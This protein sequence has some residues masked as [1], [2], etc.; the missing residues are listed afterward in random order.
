MSK[1]NFIPF[2]HVKINQKYFHFFSTKYN[3]VLKK[4]VSL[5]KF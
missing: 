5:Q 2:P 4:I 3:I 1:L